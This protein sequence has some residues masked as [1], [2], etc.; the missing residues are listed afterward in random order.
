MW[1]VLGEELGILASC[2]LSPMRRNLVLVLRVIRLALI[3][4]EIC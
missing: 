3:L 2:F 1:V 4:E